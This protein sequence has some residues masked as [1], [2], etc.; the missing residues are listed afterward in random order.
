MSP[1]HRY[2]PPLLGITVG[3]ASVT[4][5]ERCRHFLAPRHVLV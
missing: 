1:R 3:D 2:W 4:N 5:P